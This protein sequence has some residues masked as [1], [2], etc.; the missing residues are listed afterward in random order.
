MMEHELKISQ[1]KSKYKSYYKNYILLFTI[2]LIWIIAAYVGTIDIQ[3]SILTWLAGITLFKPGIYFISKIFRTPKIYKDESLQL[4]TKF[5]ILGLILGLVIGFFPFR[6]NINLFYPTFSIVFGLIFSI[7]GYAGRLKTYIILSLLLVSGG[8]YFGYNHPEQ[9]SY[10][11][12][13]SGVVIMSW[14]LLNG[15]FGKKERIHFRYLNKQF[16]N[17]LNAL[18]IAPKRF[19]KISNRKK[20]LP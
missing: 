6:E 4:I 11:G 2:G 1:L 20:R 16:K 5:I 17:Q 18:N 12:Y 8:L 7:I 15:I 9:F 10:C 14:G 19:P 3:T 13:Y